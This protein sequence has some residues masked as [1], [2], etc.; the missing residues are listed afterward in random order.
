MNLLEQKLPS[1]NLEQSVR[2]RILDLI[3]QAKNAEATHQKQLQSTT[4]EANSLDAA[5]NKIGSR[6]LQMATT[7]LVLRGLTTLWRNATDYAQQ[8][9]DKLNEIRIVTGKTQSEVSMLGQ[10]YRSLAK[11][12]KVAST[13]IATA[14]VEFWR[15]GLDEDEVN[16]RLKASIQYAKISA[17]EFDEAAE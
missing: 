7:M 16:Q 4:D 8:Y 1:L 17:M 3:N 13:E 6:L 9:Y 15:Q 10:R 2:Q 14:A 11:E 5:L 12:M